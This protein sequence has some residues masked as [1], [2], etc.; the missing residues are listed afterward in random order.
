MVASEAILEEIG[1]VLAYPRIASRHGW[2]P[3]DIATFLEDLAHLAILTPRERRLRVIP[4]DPTDDRY[5]ECAVEGEADFLVSGD[6][7]LLSLGSYRGIETSASFT[8]S[9]SKEAGPFIC[10]GA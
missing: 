7:D 3:Q 4:A 8:P 10:P 5:L 6:K 2:S 9:A 1:R